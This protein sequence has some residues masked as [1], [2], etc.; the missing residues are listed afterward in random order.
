ML[1]I[2]LT[3]RRDFETVMDIY[4][5]AREQMRL[6]GNPNQWYDKFPEADTI[7]NDI[8][9]NN[10]YVVEQNGIICGVFTFIIGKEPTYERISGSW[11][12]D[13]KY[14]TIHRIAS[15]GQQ[16]G[17]FD[18]CLKYC[19]SK[20]SNLRIDTH[21]DNKI[22]QHLIRKNG[23]ERCGIIYVRDGSPRIAYQKI[24]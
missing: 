8:D 12:N 1:K 4:R 10:S 18:L 5:Y 20:I 13:E 24:K 22:M 2:R 7:L 15:N 11:K 14:G 17:I 16:K 9:C 23:F 19:E 21:Q 6:N 3:K